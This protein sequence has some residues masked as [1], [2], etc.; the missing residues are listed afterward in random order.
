MPLHQSV[1]ALGSKVII[2]PFSELTTAS[3][4]PLIELKSIY[5]VS[6]L[7]DITETAGSGSITHTG[8]EYLVATTAS[9]TDSAKLSSAERGRYVPGLAGETGIGVRL[10]SSTATGD[11]DFKWGYY[12][13]DDGFFFGLDSTGVFAATMRAGTVTK[14]YQSNWNIDTLDGT[15]PSGINLDLTEGHIFS[16]TY[17]W[18][19]YGVIEFGVVE[20]KGTAG[21]AQSTVIPVHRFRDRTGRTSVA[22][23][24]LHIRAEINNNGTAAAGS[25]YVAGRKYSLSGNYAP[26]RRL[27]SEHRFSINT[28]TTF[29]PTISFRRK[30]GF[31]PTSVK[32]S[33][34]DLVVGAT[35]LWELRVDATLTGASWGSVSNIP[36]SET[37][38]EVD[39]SATAVSGGQKIEAGFAASGVKSQLISANLK[40]LDLPFNSTL[41]LML[42][43]ASGT[44]TAHALLSLSEEW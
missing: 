13:A 32:L 43:T 15:G 3:K 10:S 18:Y 14:T 35:S 8:Q 11:Q 39:T 16:V 21:E 40:R 44:D 9:G 27:T 22:N 6:D 7:R 23:P 4:I 25:M 28:S 30:S 37:S 24:N 5:G 29:V 34:L 17:T 20:Q 2:T 42:R 38:L 41:T 31:A 36:A 19:G 33:N 12:D 1:E 26:S